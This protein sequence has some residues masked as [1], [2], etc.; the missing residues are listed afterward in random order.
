MTAF[1]DNWCPS[2]IS[3]LV[4]RILAKKVRCL[5]KGIVSVWYCLAYICFSGLISMNYVCFTQKTQKERSVSEKILLI[6]EMQSRK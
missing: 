3:R 2:E 4:A 5:L 1:G 6:G